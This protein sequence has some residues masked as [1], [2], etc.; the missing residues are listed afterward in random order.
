MKGGAKK[1]KQ[2][3][4]SSLREV[5]VQAGNIIPSSWVF[6]CGSVATT[7]K[8]SAFESYVF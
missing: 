5:N 6:F 2:R 1:G 3:I 8:K 4:V 7:A